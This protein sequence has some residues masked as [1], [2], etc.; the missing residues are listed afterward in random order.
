ML[1]RDLDKEP[2]FLRSRSENVGWGTLF[3]AIVAL[4]MMIIILSLCIDPMKQKPAPGFANYSPDKEII[5]RSVKNLVKKKL[6]APLTA[7]FPSL[8]EISITSAKE[9][10]NWDVS[11]YVDSQNSF[12]ALIRTK[13]IMLIRYDNSSQTF[14]NDYLKFLE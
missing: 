6:K 2:K 14:Y 1:F 10:D 12:G 8:Q 11:G 7:V 9:K 4:A 5:Y 13:Y 3:K